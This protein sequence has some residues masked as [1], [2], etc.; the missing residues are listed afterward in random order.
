MTTTELSDLLTLQE[1]ADYLRVS[2]QT[3]RRAIKAKRLAA[4]RV[5]NAP[6]PTKRPIRVTRTALDTYAHLQQQ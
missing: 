3:L 1:A 6:N 5:G 2:V 4:L